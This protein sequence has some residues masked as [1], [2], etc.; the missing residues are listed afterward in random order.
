MYHAQRFFQCLLLVFFSQFSEAGTVCQKG[1]KF[2]AFG[3]VFAKSCLNRVPALKTFLRANLDN[4][5]NKNTTISDDSKFEMP[6]FRV[7][8]SSNYKNSSHPNKSNYGCK[9]NS[10]NSHFC[11]QF[12]PGH[13]SQ[14]NSYRVFR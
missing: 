4:Y 5:T 1:L 8:K 12:R 14:H 10:C 6:F 3:L 7:W 13:F 11:L 9:T 2:L